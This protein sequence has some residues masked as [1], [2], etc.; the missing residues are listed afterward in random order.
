[1]VRMSYP[2]EQGSP[3][4]RLSFRS[5]LYGFK[6]RNFEIDINVSS[7]SRQTEKAPLI[8]MSQIKAEPDLWT[9]SYVQ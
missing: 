5:Y 6:Q 1:M 9:Y 2:L 3:I 4:C 7:V 8:P